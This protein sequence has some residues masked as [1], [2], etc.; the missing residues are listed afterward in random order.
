MKKSVEKISIVF[1]GIYALLSI[2]SIFIGIGEVSENLDGW[3]NFSSVHSFIFVLICIA[4]AAVAISNLQSMRKNNFV[5]RNMVTSVLLAVVPL[6]MHIIA[7][8]LQGNVDSD[9]QYLILRNFQGFDKTYLP[10][11]IIGGIAFI[12]SLSANKKISK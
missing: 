9:F 6:I 8:S 7:N 12:T 5:N 2:I 1:Y 11:I 3:H 10:L 4:L